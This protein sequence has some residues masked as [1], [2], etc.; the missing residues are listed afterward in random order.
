MRT[1]E[2][3]LGP[4]ISRLIL[5]TALQARNRPWEDVHRVPFDRRRR[6]TIPEVLFRGRKFH[7]GS[8]LWIHLPR[9]QDQTRFLKVVKLSRGEAKARGIFME[10][11][12]GKVWFFKKLLPR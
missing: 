2:N 3:V 7:A 4:R 9:T 10:V 8:V 1:R 12:L 5:R 6:K 11:Y